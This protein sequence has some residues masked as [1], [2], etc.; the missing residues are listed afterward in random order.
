MLSPGGGFRGANVVGALLVGFS[1]GGLDPTRALLGAER[2]R[3]CTG[4]QI[5][6]RGF[7]P[8]GSIRPCGMRYHVPTIDV[9]N[10]GEV[11]SSATNQRPGHF[12]NRFVTLCTVGRSARRVRGRGR[13]HIYC[14]GEPRMAY[15]GTKRRR[16]RHAGAFFHARTAMRQGSNRLSRNRRC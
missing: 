3:R 14:G 9:A 6:F 10:S 8:L 15:H 16:L 7:M 2:R 1:V 12:Q 5:Q 11:A 4:W 13:H